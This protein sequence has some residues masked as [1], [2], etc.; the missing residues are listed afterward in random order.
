MDV[1]EALRTRRSI[2]KLDG[3]VADDDVRSLVEAALCAPNHK[4]TQPWRFTLV[5][6]DARRRLGAV[7]AEVAAAATSL[8]GTLR[9]DFIAREAAKPLRAPALL[10]VSTRTAADPVVAGEDFAATAAAAQ[11]L[12]LAAH[13]RGLGAIWR[14]G[15]MAYHPEIKAHLGLSPTDRIVAIVYVGR[16]AMRV[17]AE[18][19]RDVDAVLHVMD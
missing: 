6:G 14:T 11:N 7:W 5:R 9:A 13:A 8:D 18:R 15:A 1:I 10:V 16:P 3:E 12:L 17:P 4:L 19:M 2:G